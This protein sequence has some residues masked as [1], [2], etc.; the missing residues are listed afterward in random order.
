MPTKAPKPPTPAKK[1]HK[2]VAAATDP[3][4]AH[5]ERAAERQRDL[6]TKGREIGPPPKVKNPK[7]RKRCESS[8]KAF[9]ETYLAERF[10]IAWSDDHL[11]VLARLEGA[12]LRGGLFALAMPRGSGKTSICEAAALWAVL[13]GHRRFVAIVGAESDAAVEVIDS[14]KMLIET[15]DLLLA[16]FPEVCFPVRKLEG[17]TNRANGQTCRGVRTRIGWAQ[18]EA[19]FPTVKGSKASGSVIRVTGITGR[20]RGMKAATASGESLRPDFAIVDDPQTDESADSLGQSEKREKVIKGAVKGLAGPGKTISMAIPCTVISPGDLAERLLDRD[21]NPQ[22]RGERMRMVYQFPERQDLWDKYADMRRASFRAGGEGEEATE[23]YRANREAMDRGAVVAWPAR[24]DPESEISGLQAA[25]NLR[26][27]NPI[28]FAAEYQNEPLTQ[29]LP[30]MRSL[31]P[32][33]LAARLS[34]VPR[35]EVPRECA[36]LTAFIDVGKSVL[37][38]AVCA[39]DGRFSGSVIDYGPYPAQNRAYFRADDARPT[40]ADVYRGAGSD[41]ERLYLGLRDLTRMVL[42]TEYRRHETGEPHKVQLCLVD[43]GWKPEIVHR[44]VREA[45]THSALLRPSVGHSVGSTG[46]LVRQWNEMPG[47]TLSAPGQPA[48]RWGYAKGEHNTGRRVIFDADQW[49]GFVADR[50]LTPAGGYAPL[51]LCGVGGD[52][53]PDAHR[54]LCD[55]LASEFGGPARTA[56]LEYEKWQARP[57][58]DNHLWDCVVGCAVATGVLGVRWEVATAVGMASPPKPPRAKVKLSDLYREKHG[59]GR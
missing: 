24:F 18:K 50:F 32:V 4:S 55:H 41:D 2:S 37:W 43:R 25:M 1:G 17:Q 45:G 19:V 5:R 54:M 57:N 51:K 15:N 26:L 28:A 27:D 52:A 3:Y 6:S 11:T 49:K 33:A 47:E 10:A 14:I 42:G 34:G 31:D 36:T 53:D 16:D 46:R 35:A 29:A 44:A 9:C 12:I 48:W 22:F 21:R 58:R 40:L 8:L 7:R 23:F 56:D 38:Y 30:G 39:F 13:Y 20:V 59:S